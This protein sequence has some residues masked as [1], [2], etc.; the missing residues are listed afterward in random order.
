MLVALIAQAVP[1]V[2]QLRQRRS[3]TNF[4]RLYGVIA[5]VLLRARWCGYTHR[6]RRLS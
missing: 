6:G 5:F 1:T 4:I 2:L 3:T